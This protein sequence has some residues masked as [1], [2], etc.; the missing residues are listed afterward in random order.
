MQEAVASYK[1]SHHCVLVFEPR[2]LHALSSCSE[3]SST[4]LTRPLPASLNESI[5][6]ILLLFYWTR[7]RDW[8]DPWDIHV[9]I[10]LYCRAA[11]RPVATRVAAQQQPAMRRSARRGMGG[12]APVDPSTLP[13][14]DNVVR[15]YLK[16][17]WQVVVGILGLY[18][19]LYLFTSPAAARRKRRG[20]PSP[21]APRSPRRATR[22][23]WSP[24]EARCPP[25]RTPPSTP[26]PRCPATWPSGKPRSRRCKR[27]SN[28]QRDATSDLARGDGAW[29][30]RGSSELQAMRIKN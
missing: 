1:I 22:V 9:C 24:E 11:I 28:E 10:R 14:P 21:P 12:H 23:V 13:F 3:S 5:I 7:S 4:T 25:S 16:E 2:V 30:S 15:T 20:A 29:E 27:P 19:G 6:I 8:R 26:G 17:D 18:T